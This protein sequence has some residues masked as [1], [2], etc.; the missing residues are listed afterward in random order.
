M[1]LPCHFQ[2]RYNIIEYMQSAHQYASLLSHTL[3]K[4]CPIMAISRLSR[5][6]CAHVRGLQLRGASSGE[7]SHPDT[8]VCGPSTEECILWYL[9]HWY[10]VVRI[11]R[12]RGQ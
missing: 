5:S 12:G 7:R 10:T 8:G 1:Q 11:H 9:V 6:T 2:M 4:V 3:L